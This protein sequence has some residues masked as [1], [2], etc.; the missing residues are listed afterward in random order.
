MFIG[1]STEGQDFY[2]LLFDNEEFNSEL[3]RVAVV[4]GR[5]ESEEAKW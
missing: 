1:K 5:L 4:A 2:N 3:G